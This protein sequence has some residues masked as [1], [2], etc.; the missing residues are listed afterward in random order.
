[1]PWSRLF[2]PICCSSMLTIDRLTTTRRV[3]TVFVHHQV[4]FHASVV[5]LCVLLLYVPYHFQGFLPAYIPYLRL[6]SPMQCFC[7]PP[8]K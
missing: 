4:F 2:W 3:I 6:I 8:E 5:F 7:G 1:M